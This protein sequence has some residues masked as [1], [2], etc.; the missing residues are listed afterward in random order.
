[1]LS[2]SGLLGLDAVVVV[3]RATRSAAPPWPAGIEEDRFRRYGDTTL[4]YGR[5]S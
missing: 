4:W 2:D 3:E 1:M 5:A